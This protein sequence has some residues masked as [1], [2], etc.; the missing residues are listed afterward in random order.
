MQGQGFGLV[1]RVPKGSWRR[2][3]VVCS[4]WR[5]VI[6]MVAFELVHRVYRSVFDECV[7][8]CHGH[9]KWPTY[10]TTNIVHVGYTGCGVR[11]YVVKLNNSRLVDFRFYYL[12]HG[13]GR[14]NFRT[15]YYSA[16]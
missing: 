10:W 9:G 5:R 13:P 3:G 1:E 6:G 7:L 4:V 8:I 16:L 15:F 12:V 11:I 2:G 14:L